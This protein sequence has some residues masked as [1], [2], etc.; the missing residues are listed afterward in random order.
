MNEK[1]TFWEYCAEVA[2]IMPQG[3]TVNPNRMVIEDIEAVGICFERQ[4]NSD[5]CRETLLD[6]REALRV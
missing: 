4:W 1:L 6:R 5:E 3:Q 2:A